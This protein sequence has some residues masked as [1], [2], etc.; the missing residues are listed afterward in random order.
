MRTSGRRLP[1]RAVEAGGGLVS[2]LV[3]TYNGERYVAEALRSVVAQTHEHLEIVVCDDGSDDATLA[4]ARSFAE[5][6]RRV[7]VRVNEARL[8]PVGN[9]E[10]CLSHASGGFVK[11]L[12]QDDLLERHAVERLVAAITTGDDVVLA[13][14]RRTLV[15]ERGAPLPD[16]PE[17][18]P[19]YQ[20]D[21]VVDGRSLGDLVLQENLNLI[22][23]PSTV[24]FR[25]STLG[26]SAPFRLGGARYRYLAD[27]ALWVLLLGR[28]R[29]AYLVEPL[30]RSRQHE[31]QDGRVRA[32]RVVSVLEWQRLHREARALGF[33]APDAAFERACLRWLENAPFFFRFC[34]DVAQSADLL[35]AVVAVNADLLRLAEDGGR[36]HQA[37]SL[38]RSTASCLH[39]AALFPVAGLWGETVHVARSSLRRRR[40]ERRLAATPL[41]R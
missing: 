20:R 28:G 1:W 23:E 22:G 10:R 25:R 17:V 7:V 36:R 5:D 12:M 11:Y 4:V 38:L 30:S 21:T 2:V 35:Q 31:A 34:T 19:P 16:R 26:G 8:G 37:R 9:F 40:T 18:S 14:S 24:L 15:D 41:H 3:P 13:T 27:M 6:D 29:A 32:N 39:A 33:L